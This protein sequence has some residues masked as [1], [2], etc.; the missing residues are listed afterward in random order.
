MFC[1]EEVHIKSQR[2][3][4]SKTLFKRAQK[5]GMKRNQF[6]AQAHHFDWSIH[7]VGVALNTHTDPPVKPEAIASNLHTFFAN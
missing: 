7:N 2:P 3:P 6:Y 5:I 4:P 1:D